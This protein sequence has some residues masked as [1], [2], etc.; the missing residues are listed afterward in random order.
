MY[1][2]LDGNSFQEKLK[3]T[4]NY[5]KLSEEVCVSPPFSY[6]AVNAGGSLSLQIYDGLHSKMISH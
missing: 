6:L 3:G 2:D 1:T 4:L 5:C